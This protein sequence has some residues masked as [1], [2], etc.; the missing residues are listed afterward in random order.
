MTREL[1]MEE[2]GRVVQRAP[3][4]SHGWPSVLQRAVVIAQVYEVKQASPIV[5]F[6]LG[7]WHFGDASM[8]VQLRADAYRWSDH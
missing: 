5:A 7:V 2:S 6:S 1:G 4:L 3:L 8:Q